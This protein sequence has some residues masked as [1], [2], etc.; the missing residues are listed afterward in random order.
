MKLKELFE[1]KLGFNP[2]SSS[3]DSETELKENSQADETRDVL[4]EG[5]WASTVTQSTKLFPHIA[6]AAAEIMRDKFERDFNKFL[7]SEREQPIKIG[8]TVGSSAYFHRDSIASPTKEYGDIDI[9]FTIPRLQGTSVEKNKTH[10]QELVKAF[11]NEK[12]PEYV[13]K[14][15]GSALAGAAVIVKVG[16]EWVQVD[17]I[18]TFPELEDWATHRMTPEHGLKGALLGFMYSALAETLNLSIGGMGVQ[19]KHSGDMLVPF[20]K[21]K[22]DHVDTVSTDFGKFIHHIFDYFYNRARTD[23]GQ[24]AVP[25][26][27]KIPTA[28]QKNPG[29]K[30]DDIKASDLAASI[31][32]LARAFSANNMFG[33]GD[34]KHISN[35]HDFLRQIKHSYEEK[36]SK[37]I[38]ATKFDKAE[39][40]SARARAE[41][42]K[43]TL[44]SKS[45]ELMNLLT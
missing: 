15:E 41:A 14:P 36:I 10:Y 22:V 17:L 42:T 9:I 26:K 8:K 45:T 40:E 1:G 34:L 35:E 30:R 21:Q 39:T 23:A 16:D 27:P 12:R 6:R 3:L 2:T 11:I 20:K 19:A 18:T 38:G 24:T 33:H 25:S 44:R 29:M 13:F 7:K 5:G 31:R 28:L 37:A 43:D 4:L 32:A